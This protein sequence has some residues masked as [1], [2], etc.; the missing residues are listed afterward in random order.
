MRH[1]S[2][3]IPAHNEEQVILNTLRALQAAG[4]ENRDIYVVDDCSTDN[5]SEI[6]RKFIGVNLLTLT[7]NVGKA[8]ALRKLIKH[9]LL[10]ERYEWVTFLDADTDVDVNFLT[11][12]ENAISAD[13]EVALFVGQVKARRGSYLTALRAVEYAIGQ[14]LFKSGMSARGVIFVA[15]GCASVYRTSMLRQLRFEGDTLA[16]DMDLTM[17]V[18]RKRGKIVYIPEA[19]VNTQDPGTVKDYTK[20]VTRWYRGTWQVLRKYNTLSFTRKQKVD[21]WIIFLMLDALVFNRI[22]WLIAGAI[23]LPV[24]QIASLVTLDWLFY[25]AFAVYAAVK[26]KRAD[27]IYKFPAY[28]WASYINPVMFFKTF[29]E[30]I[31]F[32][33]Q[34]LVWNKVQRY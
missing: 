21:L 32:K 9:F 17:Q 7:Q 24:A 11:A 25:F 14:D 28:F 29:W 10:C 3:I 20:Q 34:L 8:N 16:E 15:P 23:L 18:Q 1:I 31:V 4:F 12:T 2:V 22:M 5:T 13:P 33:K 26:T 6:V 30:V 27:V 19:I